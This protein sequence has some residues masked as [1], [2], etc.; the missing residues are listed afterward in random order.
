MTKFSSSLMAVL[1]ILLFAGRA[2]SQATEPFG[3]QRSKPRE[4]PLAGRMQ[5]GSVTSGQSSAP[6]TASGSVNT[7]NSSVQTE[8]AFQGSVPAGAA[9]TEPLLLPLD[10]A[11]RRGLAYNLGM[12]GSEQT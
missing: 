7:L 9:T 12:V 1:T 5:T 3:L 4:L 6:V 2:M 8:G 10:D 11:V